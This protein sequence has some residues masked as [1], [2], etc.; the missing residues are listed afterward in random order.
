MNQQAEIKLF[1][2]TIKALRQ[3]WGDACRERDF[4]HSCISCLSSQAIR[5]LEVM[6]KSMSWKP[7]KRK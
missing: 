2:E 7:K 5:N 1:K 6:I 4:Q 3:D